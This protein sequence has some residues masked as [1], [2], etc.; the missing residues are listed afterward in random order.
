MAS[1][2]G[3]NVVDIECDSCQTVT[4]F[5][6]AALSDYPNNGEVDFYY[7]VN[8]SAGLVGKIKIARQYEPE[9]HKWIPNIIVPITTTQAELSQLYQQ[10]IPTALA[11]VGIP[12]DDG[13]TFTGD[14][15]AVAVQDFLHSYFSGQIIAANTTLLVVFSDNSTAEYQLTDF[16]NQLWSFLSGSGMSA[17]GTPLDDQ[18]QPV[19][20]PPPVKHPI[21]VPNPEPGFS[22]GTLGAQSFLDSF[23]SEAFNY[24]ANKWEYNCFVVTRPWDPTKP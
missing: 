21:V 1:V 17:S 13:T 23:C 22:S 5:E 4:D 14:A 2:W 24:G 10:L 7:V 9:V 16:N 20:L 15:Q 11:P 12:L 18:G 3:S 8:F 19:P 6:N